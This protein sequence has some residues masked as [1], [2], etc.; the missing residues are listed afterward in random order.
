MHLL[1]TGCII[2]GQDNIT[3]NNW[4]LRIFKLHLFLLSSILGSFTSIQ[5]RQPDLHING[6]YEIDPF[7]EMLL[8]YK[9]VSTNIFI[10]FKTHKTR[11]LYKYVYV[12]EIMI[13]I[14]NISS[15]CCIWAS[16]LNIFNNSLVKKLFCHMQLKM[17]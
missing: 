14:N 7:Y 10:Q 9:Y 1:W 13:N 11:I 8:L 6:V 16:L 17:M 15:E 5:S 12:I 4:Y 2:C 3:I